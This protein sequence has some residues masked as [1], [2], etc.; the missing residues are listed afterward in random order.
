MHGVDDCID[1]WSN[2]SGTPK[3]A[4]QDW[5]AAI[6]NL[7]DRRSAG[8]KNKNK[9][10]RSVFRL[11]SAQHCLSELQSKYVMVPID[12]ASNNIAFICKRFYAQV[13]VEELGLVGNPSATYT[14]IDHLTPDTIINKH[15]TDMKA[16]FGIEVDE[17]MS[18]LPDI[19]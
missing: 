6:S 4:F 19:Y 17:E 16:K 2:K 12:K 14:K 8:L 15:Q 13:I 7:I 5:R 3:L 1:S 11:P 9:H 18:T 10:K